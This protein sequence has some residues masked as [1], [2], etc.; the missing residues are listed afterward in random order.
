MGQFTDHLGATIREELGLHPADAQ[1]AA[2]L[3][4]TVH[5]QTFRN[6][7]ALALAGQS[8]PAAARR[9]RRDLERAYRLLEHGLGVL[10]PTPNE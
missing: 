10:D 7:R 4:M 8:G 5:W 9:L 1:I 6:A 3:L 2:N